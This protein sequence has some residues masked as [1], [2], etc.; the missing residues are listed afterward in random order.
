MV[1]KFAHSIKSA[2]LSLSSSTFFLFPLDSAFNT[3]FP[4]DFIMLSIHTS[5]L[6][7]RSLC[8]ISFSRSPAHYALA[9]PLLLPQSDCYHF[10]FW[11]VIGS[12]STMW[13]HLTKSHYMKADQS[14]S[15]ACRSWS[16][17]A[18]SNSFTAFFNKQ[19]TYELTDWLDG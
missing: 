9:S 6:S 1:T 2:V 8:H 18:H 3:L 5:R 11:K 13:F 16:H 15:F 4:V 7:P 17:D 19:T 12:S 10:K 14:L